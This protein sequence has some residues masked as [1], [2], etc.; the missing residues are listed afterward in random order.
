MGSVLLPQA[1]P[2]LLLSGYLEVLTA[3][4]QGC[5]V[6]LLLPGAWGF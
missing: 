3:K 4:L 5:W 1:L 6:L 2:V